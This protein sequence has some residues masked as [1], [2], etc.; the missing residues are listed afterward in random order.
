ML[1]LLLPPQNRQNPKTTQANPH[2]FEA[3]SKSKVERLTD[4]F[5]FL[6]YQIEGGQV[7]IRHE[8]IL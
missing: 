4:P 6:G 8:S 1:C 3:G 2:D 7:L 5:S